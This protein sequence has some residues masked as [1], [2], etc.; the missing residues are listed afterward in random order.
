MKIIFLLLAGTILGIMITLA[1]VD[2]FGT[3][4]LN[5]TIRLLEGQVEKANKMLH[6]IGATEGTVVISKTSLDKLIT[7]VNNP[8]EPNPELLALLKEIEDQI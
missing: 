5:R 2:T 7:V 3:P 8:A 6:R 1:I 4:S